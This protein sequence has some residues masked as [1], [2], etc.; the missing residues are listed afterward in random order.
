MKRRAYHI[1]P[2]DIDAPIGYWIMGGGFLLAAIVAG[3][4]RCLLG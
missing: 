4:S 2:T 3:V 1:D